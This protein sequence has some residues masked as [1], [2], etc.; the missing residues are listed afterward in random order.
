MSQHP[1]D[2]LKAIVQAT[3][4]QDYPD[5]KVD[6][7]FEIFAAHQVLK[8]CNFDQDPNEI[9]SGI[10][11]GSDDGGVDAF[12]LFVNRRMIRE[13]TDLSI[14]RGQQLNIEVVIVQA[15]IRTR[16]RNPFHRR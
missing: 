9:E 13:D 5:M 8:K 10:V 11:G 1:H 12:Y 4:Q 15:K 16:S 7:Y 6:D 3:Q 2:L 14:F